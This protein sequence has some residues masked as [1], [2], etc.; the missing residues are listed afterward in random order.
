[1]ACHTGRRTCF[2]RAARDGKLVEIA[3]PLVDPAQLYGH[4]HG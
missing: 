3:A 1:V 4:T 2:Y